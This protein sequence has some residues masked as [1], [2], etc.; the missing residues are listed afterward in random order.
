MDLHTLVA[1]ARYAHSRQVARIS[2][3]LA[4]KA[5]F[6][7]RETAVITQAAELHD[8]GKTAL[9]PELLNKPGALT[10]GEFEL[11][12]THTTLGCQQITDAI[13]ILIVAALVANQHHEH[14]GGNGYIG[15]AGE[16]IHPYARLI[17]VA[18]VFDALYSRRAYK[19]PW[20]IERIRAYFTEQSG[21]QID[22]E[23]VRCLFDAM[24]EILALYN[25]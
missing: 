5:G 7:P 12:K 2:A 4:E 15:L 20:D 21:K 13:D 24:G 14:I 18:D 23:V 11:V 10:A 6:E 16:D 19:E 17:A 1:G 22:A 3:L 9:P 8:I 25:E